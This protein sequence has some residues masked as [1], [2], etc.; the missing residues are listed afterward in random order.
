MH[1]VA[2]WSMGVLGH[3]LAPFSA[4][5]GAGNALLYARCVLLATT[6]WVAATRG[7]V[8]DQRWVAVVGA[9]FVASLEARGLFVPFVVLSLVAIARSG[10]AQVLSFAVGA[11]CLCVA[12]TLLPARVEPLDDLMVTDADPAV[13]TIRWSGRDNVFRAR[14]WAIRWAATER[15]PGEGHLALARAD[16]AVGRTE[17][18]RKIAA[19]VAVTATD[20]VARQQASAQLAVWASGRR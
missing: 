3:P 5:D 20:E 6:W 12:T 11:V 13:E 15:T 4:R 8:R 7:G 2:T 1:G 18:A 9:G 16:W 14:F 17:E 10:R 19:R